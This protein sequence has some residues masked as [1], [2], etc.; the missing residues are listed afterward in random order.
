M[1]MTKVS[2]IREI[3]LEKYL[4]NEITRNESGS[5]SGA[6]TIEICGASF[7]ADSPA[8][9]GT[10]NE[11]YIAREIEW[12]LSQSLNVNDIP[13][14]VPKIWKAVSGW[15]GRINSNYGFLVFHKDNHYQYDAALNELVRN[16]ASRRASIIYNRPTIHDEWDLHDMRDFICTNVVQYLIRDNALHVIVQMRSNDA[17]A[18]YRNDYAWQKFVQNKMIDDYHDLTGKNLHRGSIIW[19]VASLH[20]YQSQ[21][22]LLDHFAKTGETDIAFKR[23]KEL[24]EPN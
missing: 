19:Q 1:F 3:F 13:G 21:F 12:Y 4:K 8:I 6:D 10:P 15:D 2:N 5:L 11:D 23:Y 7:L 17:W 14:K 22:Y 9:F 16:P 20:I 24:Y 18:G